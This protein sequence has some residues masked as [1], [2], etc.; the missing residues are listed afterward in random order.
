MQRPLKDTVTIE[1]LGNGRSIVIDR[2]TQYEVATSL[3]RPS[4]ARFELGDETTWDDLSRVVGI[5][6]RYTVSVNGQAR[7]TGRMLTKNLVA[8]ASSG[9]TIQLTVQTLLADA[10]FTAVDPKIGVSNTTLKELVLAAFRR[11]GVTERDFIFHPRASRDAITGRESGQPSAAAGLRARLHA[12]ENSDTTGITFQQINKK[13]EHLRA[14]LAAAETR[15]VDPEL[16]EIK[17]EEARPHPPESVFAF[18][19]R[20]LARHGLMMWDAADG[21][22]VVGKPD[23]GQRP[24]YILTAL[25]GRDGVANNLLDARKLEDYEQVP[26]LI[27]VYGRGGGRDL[28]KARVKYNDFDPTLASVYPPLDRVTMILDESIQTQEQAEAR[29]RRE[30]LSR[31][32][33]KDAWILETDGLSYW[34][35]RQSLPYAIDTVAD[36]RVSVAGSASGAYL[37]Y[38]CMMS[39]DA[40][41]GH[42]TRLLTVGRGIWNL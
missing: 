37:I 26:E 39:G 24:L 23:D 25:R 41:A 38:E 6:G 3:L 22:I 14:Q 17:L 20:H 12:L 29:A 34:T 4:L 15:P 32:M 28:G 16:Q 8:S 40:E 5:G 13:R 7:V 36:V 42:T 30:L 1:S 2:S 9:A 33:N 10:M 27:W 19:D 11:L 18:V 21:K 31:S 35:G